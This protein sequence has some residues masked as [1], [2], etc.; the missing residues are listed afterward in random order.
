M[1][2]APNKMR[3]VMVIPVSEVIAN[4]I[5]NQLLAGPKLFPDSGL[6]EML[7]LEKN[8]KKKDRKFGRL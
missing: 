8:F 3:L 1:R 6:R 7:W 2:L 5:E 4:R